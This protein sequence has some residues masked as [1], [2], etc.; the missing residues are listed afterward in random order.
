M[1]TDAF[2][3]LERLRCLKLQLTEARTEPYLWPVRA[4]VQFDLSGR[5]GTPNLLK[6]QVWSSPI[7]PVRL[8][9]DRFKTDAEL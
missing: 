1:A 4:A 2:V 3:R 7:L 9:K 8:N 5:A 6:C